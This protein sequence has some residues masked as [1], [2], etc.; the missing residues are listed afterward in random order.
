MATEKVLDNNLR[1]KY[2][3]KVCEVFTELGEE[4]LQ[5]GSNEIAIPCVDEENNDKFVTIKVT[6]PKGSRDGEPY[7]GYAMC[8]DYAHNKAEAEEKAKAKAEAKAK[9]I[10][11]DKVKREAMK[12][13]KEEHEK[14]KAE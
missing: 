2:F 6:V 1:T 10:A 9:K 5:V 13:A 7:D 4:V 11:K 12:K 3:L 8:S 14:A